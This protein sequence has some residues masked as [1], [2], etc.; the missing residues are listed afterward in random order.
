MDQVYYMAWLLRTC[1]IVLCF[2][3][4]V[5]VVVIVILEREAAAT[6]TTKNA[7]S[8]MNRYIYTHTHTHPNKSP[9]KFQHSF[10]RSRNIRLGPANNTNTKFICMESCVLFALFWHIP[11]LTR[12]TNVK[13]VCSRY[14]LILIVHHNNNWQF[15]VEICVAL[16]SVVGSV[17]LHGVGVLCLLFLD[18][19]DVLCNDIVQNVNVTAWKLMS[20]FACLKWCTILVWIWFWSL[21]VLRNYIAFYSA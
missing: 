18:W 4:T 10:K 8:N 6:T 9:Q 16:G 12:E 19:N 13:S 7:Q 3:L 11:K 1:S 14:Y 15:S 17:T 20:M 21:T 5:F 2:I